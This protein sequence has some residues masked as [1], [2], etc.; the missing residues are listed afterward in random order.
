MAGV[1][2]RGAGKRGTRW[3]REERNLEVG[4]GKGGWLER[5]SAR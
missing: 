1:S 3:G 4:I 2:M 5:T